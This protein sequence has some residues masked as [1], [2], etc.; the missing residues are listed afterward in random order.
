MIDITNTTRKEYPRH[1]YEDIVRHIGGKSYSLSLV[2]IG[3]TR[4]RK[5]NNEHR[6][7]QYVANVLSFPL[8]P[9]VGEIYICL[10]KANKDAKKFN[11]TYQQFVGDLFIHGMLHLKGYTHGSTMDR[12]EASLRKKFI[13]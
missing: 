12:K 8:S 6:N 13:G 7:K 1:R 2:F 5:L 3:E 9:K 4:S 10:S 11:R